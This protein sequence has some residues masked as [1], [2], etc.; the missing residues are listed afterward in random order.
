MANII[1]DLTKDYPERPDRTFTFK[2]LF[3]PLNK[4]FEPITDI[5]AI[6]QSLRNIFNWKQ[7]QRILNPDFGN[8][9]YKFLYEPISGL[10]EENIKLEITRMLKYEPRINVIN[11][12]VDL[13]NVDQIDR[14]EI[15]VT[16]I[17]KI[18]RLSND[19]LTDTYIFK[20]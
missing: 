16:I 6:Y 7:G 4:R 19:Q 20:R 8:I 17:Y 2:D 9:I 11:I 12:K 13:S 14:N 3:E 18:P 5:G 10:L 15:H 1:I